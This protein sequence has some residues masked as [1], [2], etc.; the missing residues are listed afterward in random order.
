MEP[1]TWHVNEGHAAFALLERLSR[2]LEAG[3]PFETARKAVE[4]QP[5]ESTDER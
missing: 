1:S 3:D 5:K 4:S 2:R